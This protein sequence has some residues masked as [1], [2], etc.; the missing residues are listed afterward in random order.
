MYT[1][2]DKVDVEGS[3]SKGIAKLLELIEVLWFSS[4]ICTYVPGLGPRGSEL[5]SIVVYVV[6][7]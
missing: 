6:N 4:H 5:A 3:S 1:F 2:R 7:A